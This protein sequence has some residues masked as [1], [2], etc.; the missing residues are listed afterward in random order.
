MA[1]AA[2]EKRLEPGI[3]AFR[4]AL[5]ATEE[6]ADFRLIEIG[7]FQQPGAG[8]KA[9]NGAVPSDFLRPR[10]AGR[11]RQGQRGID[12]TDILRGGGCRFVRLEPAEKSAL[13]F[14]ARF[15]HNRLV[16]NGDQRVLVLQPFSR[17]AA[18]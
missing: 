11:F 6:M 18:R 13:R 4:V 5:I 10:R 12:P 1:L 15:E 16:L 17:K 8:E 9:W 7:G 2:A 3:L 14:R